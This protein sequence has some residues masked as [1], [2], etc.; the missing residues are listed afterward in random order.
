[1]LRKE[2]G[3]LRKQNN[4]TSLIEYCYFEDG[5]LHYLGVSHKNKKFIFFFYSPQPYRR[6]VRETS[7]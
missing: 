2:H 5:V 7:M 3:L 1:M 6:M 4:I